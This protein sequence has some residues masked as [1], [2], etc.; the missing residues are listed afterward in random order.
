M[1]VNN[2]SESPVTKIRQPLCAC[3]AKSFLGL[4]LHLHRASVARMR[5]KK[6][7]AMASKPVLAD[8][9]AN[10]Q[11]DAP[12]PPGP[13]IEREKPNRISFNVT[14]EGNPDWER[15]L[16]KT[17]AQLT[18]LLKSK[19]VQKELGITEQQ[20][21]EISEIGFGEDEAN[22]LLDLLQAIDSMGA[23]KIFGVPMQVTSEAFAFT[24]DHRKK[25][26]PPLTR[27]LNKWGPSIL[28]TWKDEIGFSIIFLSVLN[29]QV[30]LMHILEA[31]RRR[32]APAPKPV[33]PI[34]QAPGVPTMPETKP[35]ANA[36]AVDPL[37][38]VG[39][40]V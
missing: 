11:T 36:V 10:P 34:S 6:R 27:L 16:P 38:E 1:G 19:S 14:P 5:T 15:M 33:T 18:D 22:A 20:A 12:E 28:K 25:M 29:T 37:A 9:Q 39:F 32:L 3:Q 13:D 31:K 2:G 8:P 4:F 17:K 35:E 30:Q 24:L 40:K 7:N 21:K 26:N 23:A